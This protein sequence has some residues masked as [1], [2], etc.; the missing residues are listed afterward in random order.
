[1]SIAIRFTQTGGPDV[2]QVGPIVETQP[3]A[4]GVWIEQEAIG[5]N[6]LDVTQRNGAV[7]IPLPS[8]VGV[9]AAGRVAAIGRDVANVTVGERVAYILGPIGGYASGRLYPA[10]NA[11]SDCPTN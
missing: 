3:G 7:P 6:Y 4:G 8:G 11:S 5:V 2:L 9:E 10:P 1:M